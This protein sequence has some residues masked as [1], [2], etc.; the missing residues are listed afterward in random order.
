MIVLLE[1][2]DYIWKKATIDWFKSKWSSWEVIWASDH[3]SAWVASYVVMGDN[4]IIR[5]A[6]N[7]P[8]YL[9]EHLKPNRARNWLFEVEEI[10]TS[11]FKRR[12]QRLGQW[13]RCLP[14][15]E[16]KE[17][18]DDLGRQLGF[19]STSKLFNTL[20]EAYQHF[21]IAR[22][23]EAPLKIEERRSRIWDVVFWRSS[24]SQLPVK[25]VVLIMGGLSRL[26]NLIAE[27]SANK[28]RLVQ[29]CI[30]ID[31]YRVNEFYGA[32][33]Y[34]LNNQHHSVLFLKRALALSDLLEIDLNPPMAYVH[35]LFSNMNN[36]P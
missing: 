1:G 21:M 8:E 17:K 2:N 34:L 35:Y 13:L 25:D 9:A 28:W 32:S 20:T 26:L 4:L 10:P 31:P 14:G 16:A 23:S 12:I 6:E 36:S 27:K 11:E 33:T 15:T 18:I 29:E 3:D 24:I 22:L 30:R 7:L 19:E 5:N